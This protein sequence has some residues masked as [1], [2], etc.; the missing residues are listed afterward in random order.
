MKSLHVQPFCE[1]SIGVSNT[2]TAFFLPPLGTKIL[3][4]LARSQKFDP[5]IHHLPVRNPIFNGGFL[6]GLFFPEIS[7][8]KG[9][10]ENRHSPIPH[11]NLFA[12][13]FSAA[14]ESLVLYLSWDVCLFLFSSHTNV[15]VC[16][17]AGYE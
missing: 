1:Y 14:K 12:H 9:K 3:R 6:Q 16:L 13:L 15:R 8:Q 4:H 5:S 17:R 2:S 10:L 7:T 11:F